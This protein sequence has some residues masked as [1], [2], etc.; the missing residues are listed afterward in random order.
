MKLRTVK[1]KVVEL[2]VIDVNSGQLQ[3]VEIKGYYGVFT[4]LRVDKSNE[5]LCAITG[6]NSAKGKIYSY[7]Y[8]IGYT[9]YI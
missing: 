1:R 2:D 8:R 6:F 7:A 4:E 9:A 3:E 5:L